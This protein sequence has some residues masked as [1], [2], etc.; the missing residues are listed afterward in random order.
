MRFL[1]FHEDVI[2]DIGL[3]LVG[4]GVQS[5]AFLYLQHGS[6]DANIFMRSAFESITAAHKSIPPAKQH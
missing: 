3:Q 5:G 2:M 1:E 4:A 6:H